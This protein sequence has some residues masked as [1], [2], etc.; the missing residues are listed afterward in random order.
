MRDSR[1][2]RSPWRTNRDGGIDN[3]HE[4]GDWT[5]VRYGRR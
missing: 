3:E 1:A 5:V 4:V 2:Q